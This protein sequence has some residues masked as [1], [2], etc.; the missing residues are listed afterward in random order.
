MIG[1]P[2]VSNSGR[3]RGDKNAAISTGLTEILTFADLKQPLDEPVRN[4]GTEP[5]AVIDEW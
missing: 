4:G 3:S 2:R 5:F 1:L